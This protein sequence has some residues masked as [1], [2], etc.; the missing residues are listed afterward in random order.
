MYYGRALSNCFV[1]F[2]Y[3]IFFEI[4]IAALL[5]VTITSPDT[6]R[7]GILWASSVLI[8][9]AAILVIFAVASLMWK[10]GPYVENCYQKNTLIGSL[11][12]KRSLN[13]EII[14]EMELIIENENF[15]KMKN[16]I[17]ED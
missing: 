5:N 2:V 12:A 1:R 8:I 14:E 7:I 15:T 10:N 4:C 6:S 13:P 16:L 17:E 3:I 9:I 11:W